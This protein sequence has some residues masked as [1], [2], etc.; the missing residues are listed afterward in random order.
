MFEIAGDLEP[1]KF[2]AKGTLYPMLGK[3]RE[4]AT[5]SRWTCTAA[6]SRKSAAA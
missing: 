2:D 4:H 1:F 6:T 5:A 3:H